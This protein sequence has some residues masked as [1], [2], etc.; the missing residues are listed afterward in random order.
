MFRDVNIEKE[1]Y[2]KG[3][4]D[5]ASKRKPGHTR[6]KRAISNTADLNKSYIAMTSTELKFDPSIRNFTTE[7]KSNK[8]LEYGPKVIMHKKTT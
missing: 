2:G 5:S 7:E 8:V 6:E 4:K 3:K 1:C